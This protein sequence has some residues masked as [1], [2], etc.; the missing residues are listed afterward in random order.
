[1]DGER[2]CRRCGCDD[3]KLRVM[4]ENLNGEWICTTCGHVEEAKFECTC[5]GC[6]AER[7]SVFQK[8]PMMSFRHSG[9]EKQRALWLS[10]GTFDGDG[11]PLELDGKN[12]KGFF[13][14]RGLA[15]GLLC[16]GLRHRK[17]R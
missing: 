4:V 12:Q 7:E 13:G 2:E 11:D 15:G 5:R 9:V 17:S 3:G 1:M 14:K 16:Q 10:A 8:I 6:E